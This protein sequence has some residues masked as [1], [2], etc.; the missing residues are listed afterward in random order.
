VN[1]YIS[2]LTHEMKHN[3]SWPTYTELQKSTILVLAGSL[4]F[5]LVV[6]VMDFVY[7]K[8]LSIFYNQF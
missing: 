6:G 7:D 4:V 2:E 8:G 5:S 1:K 3:V